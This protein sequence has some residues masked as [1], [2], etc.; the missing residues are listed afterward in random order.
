MK[1]PIAHP[2]C[3]TKP[4][5]GLDIVNRLRP[6]TFTWKEG[7]MLDVGFGAEEVSEVEPLFTVYDQKGNIEGVKYAQIT[8]ALV[9]AVK[10]QQE[11]IRRQ[12]E[13]IEA[14]KALVCG[15][16][17]KAAVCRK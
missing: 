7:G 5:G 3:V 17:K 14:L 4:I 15:K 6:I 11:Q 8:T 10:E 1:F 16:N 12:Q 13:Q 2:L 9:N